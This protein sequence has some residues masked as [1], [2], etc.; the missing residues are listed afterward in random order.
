MLNCKAF[1]ESLETINWFWREGLL[2]LRE[3]NRNWHTRIKYNKIAIFLLQ[4]HWIGLD[5][6]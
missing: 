4:V 2:S 5:N 3:A 1:C 6:R